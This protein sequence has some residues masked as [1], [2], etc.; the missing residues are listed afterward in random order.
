MRP[1]RRRRREAFFPNSSRPSTSTARTWVMTFCSLSDKEF[2]DRR[3]LVNRA[4]S[5]RQQL[6]HAQHLD[7][8]A[9]LRR[10]RERN[11]VCRHHLLE[12]RGENPLDGV[13]SKHAM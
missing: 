7:F 10:W 6:A 8:S 11:G 4:N 12:G 9:L 1:A 13:F 5:L 3:F 2:A